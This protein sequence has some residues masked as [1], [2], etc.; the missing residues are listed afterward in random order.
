MAKRGVS[1][2]RYEQRRRLALGLVGVALALA[3]ARAGQVAPAET[4]IPVA[5]ARATAAGPSQAV[6]STSVEPPKTADDEAVPCRCAGTVNIVDPALSKAIGKALQLDGA[7]SGERA[8]EVRKLKLLNASV[9]SLAGLE[10]FSR[11]ESLLIDGGKVE[12]LSSLAQLTQLRELW[13]LE[14]LA[15]ALEES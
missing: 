7:I 1:V 3:C 4:P 10:C 15:R 14:D 6:A 8:C 9:Q 12:E 2:D 5:P 11:L 13:R